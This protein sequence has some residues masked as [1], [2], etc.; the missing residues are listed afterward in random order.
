MEEHEEHLC[1]V[2]RHF[3]RFIHRFLQ[4]VLPLTRLTCI[5]WNAS[6]EEFFL[7]L[8]ARLTSAPI[9]IIPNI[10]LGLVMLREKVWVVFL[11]KNN[12]GWPMHLDS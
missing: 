11:C 2:L 7:E 12:K 6:S 8:K 3:G 1:I 9:L 4:L 5:V 10:D